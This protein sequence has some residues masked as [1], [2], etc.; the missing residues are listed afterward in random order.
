MDVRLIEENLV[1]QNKATML[2]L[3]LLE[4]EFSRLGQLKPQSVSQIELSIQELMRQIVAERISL[5]KLIA[6][7]APEAQRVGELY[8]LMEETVAKNCREM[9]KRL[10]ETEQKCAIQ[11]AKNNE[12]AMAL[13]DQSKGLLDF[14]HNQI[15]PKN[16]SAYGR[17]GRF[18]QAPSNARLLSGRL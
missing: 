16:T 2:L 18:A 5:R 7:I 11:A 12:M 6:A 9:I 14:M 8:P 13:F 4:E 10:D 17:S 15:K 1:R 3:I